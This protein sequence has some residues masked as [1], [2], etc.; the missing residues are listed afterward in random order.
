MVVNKTT[1][2][3][4]SELVNFTSEPLTQIINQ[5]MVKPAPILLQ[6]ISLQKKKFPT[7][8]DA[9]EKADVSECLSMPLND[10]INYPTLQKSKIYEAINHPFL[11][12]SK[13][14]SMEVVE[15]AL[16]ETLSRTAVEAP[17]LQSN[18]ETAHRVVDF[19]F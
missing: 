15:F 1:N 7:L 14:L 11:Q 9:K 10:A 5:T 3:I 6:N 13:K 8:W 19:L 18:F 16:S 2:Y 4:S 12:K 17:I